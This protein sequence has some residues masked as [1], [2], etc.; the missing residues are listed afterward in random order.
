MAYITFYDITQTDKTQLTDALKETDHHWEFVSE[1]LSVDNLHPETEVLSVFVT[2]PVTREIIER[3]PKLKLIACRSTGFDTI[4]AIAAREHGVTVVNVPSYGEHTVAEYAFTLILALS[5]KLREAIEA[6]DNVDTE[7]SEITGFDLRDKTIGFIGMGRI[8]ARAAE[9][10]RGFGMRMIAYDPYPNEK[11]ATDLGFEYVPIEE[12][13]KQSDVVSIHAPYTKEN[14]HI[15]GTAFLEQMKPTAILVNTA[16]GELVD[17]TALI[18]AL[19]EHRIAG[20][21]LDVV[22]G[23]RLL[24]VENE[25]PLLNQKTKSDLM[26]AA[27]QLDVLKRLPNLILTPHNAFNT[28]E[29]IGRINKTTAENI[30]GFWTGDIPNKVELPP[31]G[32]GKLILVRHGESEWNVLGKWT[33]TTDVHLTEK[34]FREAAMLGQALEDVPLDYA[35]CSQQIR[36]LE[37]LE[38]I[39]D[40]S[41]QF[42]VQFERSDAINE[43]DYG[44]YTG[45]NKWEMRDKVG[46]E[47]FNA[48]R[49]NWDHPVP[50][51]ET[52]KMV[53]ERAVPFYQE[54]VLPKI[55]E[56]KNVLVVAHGNSIRALTKYIESISDEGIADVEMPFG[57]VIMY[58]VAE[59]GKMTSKEERK[60]DIVPPHA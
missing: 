53:Y 19:T 3:L 25:L 49:R 26:Q 27:M 41:R 4:D 2:S 51:G 20:A 11:R 60:I 47:E 38:G 42:D 9:I 15:V 23:E 5:R 57:K 32:L 18:T 30:I 56:G 28:T 1:S 40:A 21:A 39:L 59:D 6:V 33:G 43:R 48:I 29:A 46:E 34:G 37:T 17:T 31:A 50:N 36:A 13:A 7:L 10:A 35:Y 45:M 52:L 55:R 8:G 12:I 14:R 44:D 58:E 24:K 54:N 22:E 16:R